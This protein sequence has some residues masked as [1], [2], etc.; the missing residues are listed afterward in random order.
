[1]SFAIEISMP[2]KISRNIYIFSMTNISHYNKTTPIMRAFICI[3]RHSFSFFF[4]LTMIHNPP[5]PSPPRSPS[6]QFLNSQH[7][8]SSYYFLP[9][10]R[11]PQIRYYFTNTSPNTS[12]LYTILK[13]CHASCYK[14]CGVIII[15]NASSAI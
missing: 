15:Y 10:S 7:S 4:F 9:L 1:M 5:P 8:F 6:Q 3:H 2:R 14:A 13:L 12:S 11:C